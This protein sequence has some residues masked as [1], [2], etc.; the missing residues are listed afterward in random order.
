MSQP[1][2]PND[3]SKAEDNP[4]DWDAYFLMNTIHLLRQLKVMDGL[5]DTQKKVVE[6]HCQLRA[7]TVREDT[8]ARISAAEKALEYKQH[9]FMVAL[10]IEY[11]GKIEISRASFES[12]NEDDI[13]TKRED[14]TG[15]KIVYGLEQDI[16]PT[17]EPIDF[18]GGNRG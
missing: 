17:K 8:A 18:T 15:N 1:S 5:T 2:L 6:A 11:G 14:F 10:L 3:A 9:M 13:I 7:A 4:R 12:A 16:P